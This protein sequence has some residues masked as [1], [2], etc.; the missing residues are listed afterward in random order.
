MSRFWPFFATYGGRIAC[1]LA[2]LSEVGAAIWNAHLK[3]PIDLVSFG[4][5]LS[6]ILLASATLLAAPPAAQAFMA[7][8]KR[9]LIQAERKP[10]A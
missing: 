5:G 2:I 3:Q 10:D 1:A 7:H 8:A 4:N 6:A 9:K